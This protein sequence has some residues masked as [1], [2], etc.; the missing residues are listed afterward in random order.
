MLFGV[1]GTLL[2][3]LK[4]RV[5]KAIL[6]GELGNGVP[7]RLYIIKE[8]V[9]DKDL[10]I[11][12]NRILEF[13]II[14]NIFEKDFAKPMMYDSGIEHFGFRYTN[15]SAKHFCVLKMFRVIS[16]LNACVVLAEKSYIQEICVLI[17]SIIE[18]L[19][20]VEYVLSGYNNGEIKEKQKLFVDKFFSD[21]QRNSRDDYPKGPLRRQGKIHKEVGN[22]LDDE[23]S[24]TEFSDKYKEVSAKELMSNVYGA[25]SNYVHA[26]YPEIMDMYGGSPGHFHLNGMSGTPKDS[27]CVDII[28]CFMD[29]TSLVLGRMIEEFGMVEKMINID[30]LAHWF[31][32]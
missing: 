10:E 11:I 7:N 8:I 9:L 30:R 14:V 5:N 3:Q 26:R 6:S 17:R 19:S 18:G 29:S 12:R 2:R 28:T 13:S 1:I 32:K 25:F 20:H 27:E 22:F 23:I 16:G 31:R 4:Y 21:F 15:T 24:S